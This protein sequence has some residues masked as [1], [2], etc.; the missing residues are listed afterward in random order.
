MK[1]VASG[2][3]RLLGV[4]SMR[5]WIYD[6]A[7]SQLT[8]LGYRAVLDRLPEGASLLDVGVG[9]GSALARQADIIRERDLHID[10]IDIDPDYLKRCRKRVDEEHLEAHVRVIE[11]SIYTYSGGPY[12]AAY[13]S[14]SFMLMPDPLRALTHVTTLLKPGAPVFFTQTFEKRRRAWVEFIKPRLH[15]LT[16]IRFGA[17]TYKEPFLE[18]LTQSQLEVTEWVTLKPLPK[19]TFDLVATRAAGFT[20][21]P[22][23]H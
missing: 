16:T 14:A 15:R 11:Q 3:V 21:P 20:P 8:V 9:T 2:R 18:A 19:S 4:L 17:V 7:I 22:E 10:G 23:P 5:S 6:T 13:F 1:G 12:D